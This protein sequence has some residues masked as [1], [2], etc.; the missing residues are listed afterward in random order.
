MQ[1]CNFTWWFKMCRLNKPYYWHWNYLVFF[2][3]TAQSI[4][5]PFH[6]HFWGSVLIIETKSIQ[7]RQQ[8]LTKKK[9]SCEEAAFRVCGFALL[10]LSRMESDHGV[11]SVNVKL[12]NHSPSGTLCCLLWATLMPT[13][14]LITAWL[15]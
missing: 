4:R 8:S 14:H 1:C 15:G 7:W 9:C 6:L 3:L 2:L 13:L 10:E 12:H 11:C 5:N